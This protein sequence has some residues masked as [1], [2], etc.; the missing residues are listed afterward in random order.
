MKGVE[1]EIEVRDARANAENHGTEITTR[2]SGDLHRASVARI[3]RIARR[4]HI[5]R[6]AR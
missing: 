2:L 1:R 6:V 3:A 4:A 5:A